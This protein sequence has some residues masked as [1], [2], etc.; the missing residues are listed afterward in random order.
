M[1]EDSEKRRKKKENF[2]SG[3]SLYLWTKIFSMASKTGQNQIS[4]VFDWSNT[5]FALCV[6]FFWKGD[7][8]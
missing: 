3:Y 7:E 2:F 8:D 6:F 5:F 1:I 4:D